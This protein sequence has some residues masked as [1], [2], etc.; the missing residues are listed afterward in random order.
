MIR[1]QR[2][3]SY[4]E[5]HIEAVAQLPC[6]PLHNPFPFLFVSYW[7][8]VPLHCPSHSSSR[9]TSRN[10]MQSKL[11]DASERMKVTI[12]TPQQRPLLRPANRDNTSKAIRKYK[13]KRMQKET[14]HARLRHRALS[15]TIFTAADEA[16]MDDP[17]SF[18]VVRRSMRFSS[19]P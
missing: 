6:N 12:A 3:Y 5:I 16:T 13:A 14:Q 10:Q 7:H 4:A 19:W 15:P 9:T 17:Y 2:R 1:Y 8:M 18:R 11:T